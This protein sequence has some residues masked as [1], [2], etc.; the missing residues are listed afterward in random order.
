VIQLNSTGP[1]TIDY[2]DAKDNPRKTMGASPTRPCT[3]K[4]G[5]GSA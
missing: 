2:V 3:H 1:W 4:S 5:I